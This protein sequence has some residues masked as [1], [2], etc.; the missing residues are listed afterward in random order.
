MGS[1]STSPIHFLVVTAERAYPAG[2]AGRD[3]SYYD[4]ETTSSMTNSFPPS[5]VTVRSTDDYLLTRRLGTGKFSDVF[6]AVDVA[7]EQ[8]L[9]HQE[10]YLGGKNSRMGSRYGTQHVVETTP[11]AATVDPRTICVI[12]CLKPVSERKI[13]REILVLHRCRH[14][15][16]LSRLEAVVMDTTTT[17][18]NNNSNSGCDL[19]RMPSLVLEHA[20]PASQWLCHGQNNQLSPPPSTTSDDNDIATP[21]ITAAANDYY[22]S[23]YEIRYYLYHLLLA[24]DG[25]HSVGIMHRDVKPRNV[26]VNRRLRNSSSSGRAQQPLMLIDLGLADFYLPGVSY[27]VRVA[28]RH[29]KSPELLTGYERYDYAIDLWGVGCILAGLL[30]RH[31][32]F[33]RGK[34]NVDQLGKILAVLG[35]DDLLAFLNKYNV[36]VTPEV[37]QEIVKY[38]TQQKQQ[39]GKNK[40]R[41]NKRQALLDCR[42]ADCPIPNRDG[43]DLLEKLLVYDHEDRLT[44][45]QAMQHPFFDI[46]RERVLAEVRLQD[47]GHAQNH[48][49]Q[50]M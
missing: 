8:Q 35:T 22:L 4:Y 47:R 46:V 7:K 9:L 48:Q 30:L 42:A 40:Q 2:C 18:D 29:Y 38:H 13:R 11:T 26:L 44:A 31:E 3:P 28:S 32:P 37:Q 14:L 12:K 16:N 25:L 34:D 6:E 23:D 24:I 10:S 41:H 49:Q 5:W 33:F 21:T 20:G 43:M 17:T 45:R 1:G 27:N 19:A 39:H 50:A 15:L 36:Q